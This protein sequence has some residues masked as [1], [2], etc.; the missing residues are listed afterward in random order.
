M[1]ET[2]EIEKSIIYLY[3][4]KLEELNNKDFRSQHMKDIHH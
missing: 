2:D 4:Q 1:N 3:Q